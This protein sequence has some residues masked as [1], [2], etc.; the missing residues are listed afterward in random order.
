MQ[1][2]ENENRQK[3]VFSRSEEEKS[4]YLEAKWYFQ[5]YTKPRSD[6]MLRV[7]HMFSSY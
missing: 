2:T 6:F 1:E 5:W 3:K 4:N 7:Y